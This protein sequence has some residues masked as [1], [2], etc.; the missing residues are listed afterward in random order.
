MFDG[1]AK[2]YDLTNTVLS[3]GQDRSWRKVEHPL[4][5]LQVERRARRLAPTAVLP[6]REH[7]V[8]EVVPLGHAVEHLGDLMRLL[9]QIC[10]RH[11]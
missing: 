2:R 1:V 3:F 5:R 11:A 10:A 6:E 9:V 8:G 7:R 4:T